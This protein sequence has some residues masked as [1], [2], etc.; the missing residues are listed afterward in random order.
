MRTKCRLDAVLGMVS[1][2][3]KV[4]LLWELHERPCRFGE[5][6]RRLTGISEKVLSAQLRELEAD[7]LCRRVE[8][9]G[10]VLHVEYSLT[11]SGTALLEALVPITEWS[12]AHL[13]N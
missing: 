12:L 1:G 2:K 4:L 6:R 11:D 7:G 13:G 10:A 3:W 5:L 8:Y 9:P